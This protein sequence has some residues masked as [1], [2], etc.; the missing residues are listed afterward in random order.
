MFTFWFRF[1]I[2]CCSCC[3]YLNSFLPKLLPSKLVPCMKVQGL[4]HTELHHHSNSAH[5]IGLHAKLL[6][7]NYTLILRPESSLTSGLYYKSGMK[8]LSSLPPLQ[9]YKAHVSSREPER[10]FKQPLAEWRALGNQH[11]GRGNLKMSCR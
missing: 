3:K 9:I 8:R 5:V 1:T 6:N 11:A 7:P 4:N 10:Y 2:C